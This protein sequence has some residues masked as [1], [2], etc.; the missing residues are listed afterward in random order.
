M[1]D[2]RNFLGLRHLAAKAIRVEIACWIHPIADR[3][4]AIF[5]NGNERETAEN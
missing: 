1:R 4:Q 5:F 3:Q 2:Q